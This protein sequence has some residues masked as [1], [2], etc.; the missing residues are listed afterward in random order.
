MSKVSS[1]F[2]SKKNWLLQLSTLSLIIVSMRLFYLQIYLGESFTLQSNKNYTRYETLLSP[3]G[4]ILDTHGSIIATNRPVTSIYWKG[5]GNKKLTTQQEETF[6]IINN[7]LDQSLIDKKQDIQRAE[8]HSKKYTLIPDA[9]FEQL[10]KIAEIFSNNPNISI[11]TTFKRYY[12]HTTLACHLLGYLGHLDNESDN[13]SYIGGKMGIEKI[14]EKELRGKTGSLMRIVNSM[15]SH[16]AEKEMEKNH[17]GYDIITT[18][19]LEL[20]KIA[21]EVFPFDK[22]GIFILMDPFTGSLRAVLSRPSFDPN[23]FLSAINKNDWNTLQEQKSFLNRICKAVYPPGSIF[24]LVTFSAALETGIVNQHSTWYCGGYSVLNERHY[25]CAR[26]QGH[27]ELTLK[28]AFAHSCNIP[29]FDMARHLDIDT[30]ARYAHIFGL[31]EKTNTALQEDTGLIPTKEWK[32]RVKGERWWLGETFSASIGQSFLLV[33]PLQMARMVAAVETGYLTSMRITEDMPVIK[34]PLAIRPETRKFLQQAMYAV[35]TKGTARRLSYMHD[36]IIRSKTST[37]QMSGLHKKKIS[38]DFLEHGWLAA[39][40][41]YKG[42]PAMTLVILTEKTGGTE[43]PITIAKE[44]LQKYR[45][46]MK[47]RNID[48]Q[49]EHQSIQSIDEEGYNI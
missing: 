43:L 29:P 20:Q 18:L 47:N 48:Y 3:R 10:S 34:E 25:H 8:R 22:P 26:K 35:T 45:N 21:E 15:G 37:A 28:Q 30:I 19:D 49:S 17:P 2:I 23:M 40:F 44:F 4:N 36:F 16:I 1:V 11:E 5:S 31:G 9:S 38:D 33:T 14:Y 7:L 24:K 12:P 32:K 13:S 46:V 6:L 39:N 27:G 41:S 42:Q